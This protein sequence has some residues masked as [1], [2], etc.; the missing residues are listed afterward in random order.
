MLGLY[1]NNKQFMI[2]ADD[3]IPG[4]TIHS[5]VYTRGI[6]FV[7]KIVTM[8]TKISLIRTAD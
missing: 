7:A 2:G 3:I 6:T 1:M 5:T 4:A 8:T